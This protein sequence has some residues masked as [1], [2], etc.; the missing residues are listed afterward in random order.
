MNVNVLVSIYR[1]KFFQTT[2]KKSFS[3]V[4]CTGKK[5]V[6][7]FQPSFPIWYYSPVVHTTGAWWTASCT[8]QP[9]YTSPL[10]CLRHSLWMES[11]RTW[12]Q[13]S[14][15][16]VEQTLSMNE[17]ENIW[18]RISCNEHI[19][20][21]TK[22]LAGKICNTNSKF[23]HH[24]PLKIFVEYNIRQN[25]QPKLRHSYS[26]NFWLIRYALVREVHKETYF[27]IIWNL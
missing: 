27:L 11:K 10:W 25:F 8:S 3:K 9:T 6:P 19:P 22:I 23:R 12:G 26:P 1:W 5:A 4:I 13:Y 17:N 16:S 18:M 24:G 21:W 7:F 14:C 2:V 20:Y 15:E